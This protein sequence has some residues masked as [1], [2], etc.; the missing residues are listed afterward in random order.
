VTLVGDAAHLM[1]PDG[2]GANLAMYD[3]AELGKAIAAHRND[4]EAALVEYEEAMFAR[5]AKAGVEALET[6]AICFA[7]EHAPRGLIELVGG[8]SALTA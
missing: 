8:G 7:D 2:E 6:F 5:S 4:V 1:A 3:G